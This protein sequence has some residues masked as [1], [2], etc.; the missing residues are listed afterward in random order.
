MKLL[1]HTWLIGRSWIIGAALLIVV[2]LIV[3][4]IGVIP[5]DEW[6]T[7]SELLRRLELIARVLTPV[8]ILVGIYVAW[9]RAAAADR[10]AQAALKTAETSADGRI[11]ER[12]TRAIE[13]L[14]S[15][16]LSTRLGGIYALERIA[17]DSERDHWTIL[18][19]LCAYVR[20]KSSISQP[21]EVDSEQGAEPKK[22]LEDIQAILD[23]IARLSTNRENADQGLSLSRTRLD[24]ANFRNPRLVN[25][26]MSGTSLREVTINGGRFVSTDL[27]GVDLSGARLDKVDL[28]GVDLSGATLNGIQA[29]N[30]HFRR[31]DLSATKLNPRGFVLGTNLTGSDLSYA[32]LSF[33]DLSEVYADANFHEAKLLGT[34]LCDADLSETSNLTQYQIEVAV[35]NEKTRLPRYLTTPH[36]W[37]LS[38][39]VMKWN[40]WRKE[41]PSTK[42]RL[43]RAWLSGK[44]IS[45]ANLVDADLRGARLH[46]A[47]CSETNFERADIQNANIR[48]ADLSK[49][50]NVTQEQIGGAVGDGATKLPEGLHRPEH[51]ESMH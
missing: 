50:K 49:A 4:W 20:E 12:F 7:S 40:T 48:R 17:H 16:S 6:A 46:A 30:C 11:T 34:N 2:A 23:V 38:S 8:A 18:E 25:F 47:N 43:R 29:H 27:N 36:S 21:V 15:E 41:N 37:M 51:W 32:T 19:V 13:Q 33:A 10:Q 31:A 39:G 14:G 24:G 45:E 44:D 26:D 5:N 28:S 42:P 9:R 35:G 3:T 1:R 22:P